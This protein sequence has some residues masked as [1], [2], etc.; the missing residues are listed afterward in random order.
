MSRI[1]CLATACVL[2]LSPSWLC[3]DEIRWAPDFEVAQ[4]EAKDQ[5]KLILL[6]FWGSWCP[7]CR[8]VEANV[9][10]SASVA[11]TI[12]ENFVPLKVDADRQK[13]L[14]TKFGIDRLPTDVIANADGA[15]L[16][17][18]TTPQD[19]RE[20]VNQ[21]SAI[22]LTKAP[23]TAT[24]SRWGGEGPQARQS[25]GTPDAFGHESR[26]GQDVHG[27]GGSGASVPLTGRTPAGFQSHYAEP[28][29]NGPDASQETNSAP[30]PRT[31]VNTF[32]RGQLNAPTDSRFSGNEIAN[33]Y[34]KS[35]AKPSQMSDSLLDAEQSARFQTTSKPPVESQASPRDVSPIT[36]QST[37]TPIG[38]DGRCPVTLVTKRIWQKGDERY[39]AIHRG[40]L[41]LFAGEE[42]QR[43]FLES[44]DDYSPVLAGMDIVRLTEQKAVVAGDRR[45]GVLY[46]VDGPGPGPSKIYLF[47]SAESR[48]RFESAGW[49]EQHLQP[50]LQ[51]MQ[52]GTLGSYLR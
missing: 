1:F 49:P 17:R 3:A 5:N 18:M 35:G 28:V 14:C 32:A 16:H 10:P 4:Q 22:A 33:P 45:F 36:R 52:Q 30:E 29:A 12:H 46:D 47:D 27:F 24:V 40:Y 2:L 25:F 44:P 43:V 6:H 19:P 50:V 21:L 51:A 37:D 13:E 34:A 26:V 8:Q 23:R 38:L 41:Y 20:Y 31:V 7:P 15:I 39:G 48:N 9:F 11:Q 42:E